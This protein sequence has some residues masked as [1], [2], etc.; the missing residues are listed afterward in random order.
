MAPE[1]NFASQF[2][3]GDAGIPGEEVTD[4]LMRSLVEDNLL[5]DQNRRR[6]VPSSSAASSFSFTP[7]ILTSAQNDNVKQAGRGDL[8]E[9]LSGLVDFATDVCVHTPVKGINVEFLVS[10]TALLLN[11]VEAPASAMSTGQSQMSKGRTRILSQ[12]MLCTK[13]MSL[14]LCAFN[15]ES[16]LAIRLELV[17]G[18]QDIH[19]H[20]ARLFQ[21]AVLNQCPADQAILYKEFV[22]KMVR[23]NEAANTRDDLAHDADDE[24]VVVLENKSTTSTGLSSLTSAVDVQANGGPNNNDPGAPSVDRL[25]KNLTQSRKSFLRRCELQITRALTRQE[26]RLTFLSSVAVEVTSASM[27]AQD[28]MRKEY[29]IGI[30]DALACEV[31]TRQELHKIVQSNIHER[32]PWRQTV[33]SDGVSWKLDDIEDIQRIRIRLQ[34]SRKDLDPKFYRK[35]EALRCEENPLEKVLKPMSPVNYRERA[36]SSSSIIASQNN[37][38]GLAS[39][40]V[41]HLSSKDA[42]SVKHMEQCRLVIAAGEV[43]GEVL[44]TDRS[45]HFVQQGCID[46][47]PIQGCDLPMTISIVLEEIVEVQPRWYQLNDCALE[48]FV[49]DFGT[50]RML[51]FADSKS[52]DGFLGRLASANPK[53]SALLAGNNTSKLETYTQLWQDGSLT[54]FDYLMQLNKLA[55]RT[56][57]DLMQYPVFPFVLSDY[58]SDKLDLTDVRSFRDLRKPISVQFP[59]KEERYKANFKALTDELQRSH[60]QACPGVGPFHYGSHYSNTGIVLHFLVRLPPYTGLFLRYQDG[61]FDI[62]DRTFHDLEATWNLA[63][64][65]STTDVKELIPDLFCL[66]EMLVNIEQLDLGERQNGEKVDNVKLP[67]WAKGDPRLFIKI[68]RQALESDYVR[69]NLHHWIDLVF[70]YKQTGPAAVEAINV[71]HP[72]TYYGFDLDSITDPVQRRAR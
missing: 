5:F 39:I 18:L 19:P 3:N 58:S 8:V 6:R 65:N 52:R 22:A 37:T 71:F 61:S 12:E 49:V 50:T 63:A 51:A 15:P 24:D 34:R 11:Q 38:A 45:I 72:A 54:N 28:A 47:P 33:P 48:L 44:L 21:V 43:P 31:T 69:E 30:R 67:P 62:P 16:D 46:P 17:R 32:G 14:M 40:L 70:G 1:S 23:E 29:L 53:C 7:D 10:F 56:F 60:E 36:A 42:S 13:L 41:T 55:G 26:E 68:H 35:D 27:R 25:K 20:W 64:G 59:E 57:N 4:L 2:T 9:R 66:P